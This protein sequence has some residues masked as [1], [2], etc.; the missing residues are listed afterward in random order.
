M[1]KILTGRRQ[2]EAYLAWQGGGAEGRCEKAK[3][4]DEI[5]ACEGSNGK[6]NKRD[7]ILFQ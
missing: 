6:K 7:V 2:Q 4:V 3:V 5:K 1:C